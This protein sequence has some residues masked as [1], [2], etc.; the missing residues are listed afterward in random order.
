MYIQDDGQIVRV[1]DNGNGT[2]DIVVRDMGNP[3]GAP[4]T[5]IKDAS[6]RYVDNKLNNGRWE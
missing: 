3:S 2:Y 1:L 5:V 4:T 6:Q